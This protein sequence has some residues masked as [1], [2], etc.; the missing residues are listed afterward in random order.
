VLPVCVSL[1]SKRSVAP[2]AELYANPKTNQKINLK[3]MWKKYIL[4]RKFQQSQQKIATL[5]CAH[6]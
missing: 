4:V 2:H 6:S 5:K 3:T 1:R